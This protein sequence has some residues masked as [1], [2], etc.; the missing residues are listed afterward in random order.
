MA[1]RRERCPETGLTFTQTGRLDRTIIDSAT[2]RP[3]ADSLYAAAVGK[4]GLRPTVDDPAEMISHPASMAA[5]VGRSEQTLGAWFDD[6][7][8][9]TVVLQHSPEV[10][11]TM[12]TSLQAYSDL[13]TA[14]TLTARSEAGYRHRGNLIRW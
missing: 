5:L 1:K 7:K 14:E 10:R 4:G 6:S 8:C 2:T 13:K 12:A 3:T 9:H 11:V